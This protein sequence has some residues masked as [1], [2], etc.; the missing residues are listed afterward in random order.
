MIVGD[1]N[2]EP[3]SDF[4]INFMDAH[5]LYNL[6]KNKTCFKSKNGTC[7]D[8]ILTNRKHSFQF[9]G[10]LETG[11]SDYHLLIHTMMKSTYVKLPP[12]RRKF[13]DYKNFNSVIFLNELNCQLKDRNIVDYSLFEKFFVN[14]LN[15]HAPS[16]TRLIRAN[17]K[18]H[19]TKELRKAI[20]LRS[21]LKNIANNTKNPEDVARYKRQRNFVVN[22]N[23]KAK[24]SLFSK[25][26][27]KQS[28]KGFWDTFKP[29]FSNKVNFVDERIQLIEGDSILSRNIDIAE[30]FNEH[31][32]TVTERLDVPRWNSVNGEISDNVDSAIDKFSCHPSIIKIR[33]NRQD[34]DTFELSPV[35]NSETL[36]VLKHLNDSKSVSGDIP[37]KII[38]L[39]KFVCAPTLTSCFNHSLESQH[40][41]DSLK[42]AD[43]IPVHKKKS[44]HDKDN[45]RPVSLLPS[46]AKIFEK[47]I[48]KQLNIFLESFFSTKLC[49][50]RK[51]YSTQSAL[52][53]MLRKWQT[54]LSNSE[55]IGAILM[56]LSK[57]FDCLPHD[58]LIAKLHAYGLGHKS[59]ALI[60]SYLSN[61][62]HRVR[63]GSS[64]SNWL[65]LLSGVPQGSVLGPILFNV[66]IND[67]FYFV[68]ED[69]LCNFADDNTLHKCA[70]SLQEV[71][72]AL[73][74]DLQVILAWFEHNSLVANPEKFQMLFP[75]TKNAN[76]S[77]DIGNFSLISSENANLL[78][79]TI[80]SALSFYA[81]IQDLCNKAS[82]KTKTILRM[83]SYLNQDQA[84]LIFNSFIL[85]TF[86]YCPLI[87]MFCS[88]MAHNLL[89]E[90]HYRALRAKQNLLH[91][92]YDELLVKANCVSIHTQNLQ[93][94]LV[95]VYKSVN[96]IGNKLG[97]D[98]FE[99]I[100]HE[101]GSDDE[102]DDSPRPP[103]LRRGAQIK[104]PHPK[105]AVCLNSFN[106]RAGQAWNRLPN[107]IKTS[108]SL[109]CFK[110]KILKAK[111][112]CSCKLCSI[113]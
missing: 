13:R 45:Y 31:Y 90:A 70:S 24:K 65:P 63:V 8:L 91:L 14:L 83:R 58:L 59:L 75:G 17:N 41:P 69:D 104:L 100:Q 38:K 109:E 55:K 3:E 113:F 12:V 5:N 78:G 39:A 46:P 72:E 29:F 64:Y 9:T 79:I 35:T 33:D 44:K 2:L 99:I 42:Q 68:N 16:K 102:D 18:Q 19:V 101:T 37:T 23:R 86:K 54:S 85:S 11:S 62:K 28:P 95:E 66:F 80:D 15:E 56:D 112:Y 81:H 89:T 32:H 87:W 7:I 61:R 6:V 71:I 60:H 25:S 73:K 67:L 110:T 4:M 93:L 105:N 43:I 88:K 96:N 103:K 111:I 1:F 50:F 97:W 76:I 48:S 108:E 26:D 84:D 10:A 98:Q 30:T 77:I 22:M 53:N 36:K 107:E 92:D 94:M 40:F 47:L 34:I 106:Y 21:K 49:G 51:Q 27:P 57:A 20:M 52:L 82:Q 74:L